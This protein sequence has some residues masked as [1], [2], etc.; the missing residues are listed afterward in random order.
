MHK[1]FKVK[2]IVF[3]TI[4]NFLI[5]IFVVFNGNTLQTV[6]LLID[7]CSNHP[8]PNNNISYNIVVQSISISTTA[9]N[10]PVADTSTICYMCF[11]TFCQTDDG[12]IILLSSACRQCE[13]IRFKSPGRER[14]SIRSITTVH[15]RTKEARATRYTACARY[16]I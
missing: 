10:D 8:Y 15:S 9:Y 2:Y 5:A 12:H 4:F 16:I 11:L 7:Y 13:N 14:R 6:L 3:S 1:M